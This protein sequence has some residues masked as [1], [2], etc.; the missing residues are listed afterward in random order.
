MSCRAE[1]YDPAGSWRTICEQTGN[2]PKCQL[3]P[4]SPTYWR[5]QPAAPAPVAAETPRAITPW[6]T[7]LNWGMGAQTHGRGLDHGDRPCSICDQPSITISPPSKK[8][9]FGVSA[10][11]VCAEQWTSQHEQGDTGDAQ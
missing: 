2:L 6:G 1:Q 5:D 4:R 8:H 3:C 10:H 11:K 7:V 9:P